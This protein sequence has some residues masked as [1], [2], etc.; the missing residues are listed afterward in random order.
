[1]KRSRITLSICGVLLVA[2]AIIPS[3]V[4]KAAG[5]AAEELMKVLPDSIEQAEKY[6]R[7]SRVLESPLKPDDFDGPSYIYVTGHSL[8][9]ESP[10]KQVLVYENPGYLRDKIAVLFLDGHVEVMTRDRFAEIIG[11]TC[12]Q[13]GREMPEIKFMN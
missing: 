7:N 6:Y 10:F 1:M 8:A 11:A 4:V 3:H 2:V 9:A 5:S 12:K 13:L